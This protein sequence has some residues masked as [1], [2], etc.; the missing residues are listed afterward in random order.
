MRTAEQAIHDSLWELLSARLS[1]R[2]YESRPETGAEYP[3]A[4]FGD[5]ETEYIGTK[6]G[7]LSK[8]SV[9]LNIWDT[10]ENRK[11]VSDLCGEVLK[12]AMAIS[13]SY[14]FR[15]SPVIN[16][17]GIKITQDRTGTPPLWRGAV[18]LVFDIL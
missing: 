9:S 5:F 7:N 18:K 2:V 3:L 11:N 6:D 12:E 17:S 1:E 16:H 4:D 14:G 15:V 10:E 13:D 8:V